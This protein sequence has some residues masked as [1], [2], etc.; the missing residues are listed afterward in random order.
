MGWGGCSRK[1]IEGEKRRMR[2]R[3]M[4]DEEREGEDREGMEERE[5]WGKG[6]VS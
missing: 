5:G 2:W 6:K 3:E 1:G 4:E